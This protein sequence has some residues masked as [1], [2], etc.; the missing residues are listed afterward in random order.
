HGLVARLTDTDLERPVS[1]GGTVAETLL[2]VAFGDLRAAVLV[3]RSSR[4]GAATPSPTDVE[5]L[6]DT[7]HAMTRSIPLRAVARLAVE[8]AERVDRGL[9]AMPDHVMEM[10]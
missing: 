7:I 2:H 5:V 3:E 8:A 6:N 1:H 4:Q 10:I 9:E